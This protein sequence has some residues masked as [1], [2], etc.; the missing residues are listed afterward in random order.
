MYVFIFIFNRESFILLISI[1]ILCMNSTSLFTDI[2]IA[3][4]LLLLSGIVKVKSYRIRELMNVS[5]LPLLYDP[6]EFLSGR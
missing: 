2:P 1:L 5:C 6:V 4:A 3:R